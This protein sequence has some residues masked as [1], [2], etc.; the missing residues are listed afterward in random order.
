MS[1]ILELTEANFDDVIDTSQ[2]PILVDLWA[3]WCAPCKMIA[4]MLEE[5]ASEYD[6][7]LQIAKVDV[8]AEQTLAQKFGVRSIPTLAFVHKG[9]VVETV[10]GAVP[11]S[12]LVEV[13]ERVLA[14]ATTAQ[15]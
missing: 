15:A 8:D 1:D 6:G 14:S 2:I 4:P 3:S 5:L 11:R 12:Q 13:T 9:E 10:V 7:R